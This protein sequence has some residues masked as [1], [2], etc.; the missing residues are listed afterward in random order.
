MSGKVE[1]LADIKERREK[2]QYKSLVLDAWDRFEH[3]DKR[4]QSDRRA[5][6]ERAARQ[7]L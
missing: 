5:D 6:V 3:A 4:E 2:Q 1:T 7:K